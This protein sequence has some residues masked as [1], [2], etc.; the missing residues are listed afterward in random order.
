MIQAYYDA[1]HSLAECEARFGFSRA[2]WSEAVRRGDVQPRPRAMPLEQLLGGVRQRTHLKLRLIAAGLKEDRCEGCGIAEWRQA[3]LS[4]ALHHLN[5][6]GHDNRL[7][8]L[9]LLCPNCHSQTENFGGR[10]RRAGR[11][12]GA[13]CAAEDP[14]CRPAV[15]RPVFG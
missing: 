1:G 2:S 10:K 3:P 4:L 7:E 5:G 13:R 15:S 12:G 8:N 11:G 14:T 6:D 9:Q